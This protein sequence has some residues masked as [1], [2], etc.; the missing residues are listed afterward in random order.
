VL[1]LLIIVGSAI[2]TVRYVGVLGVAVLVTALSA[3]SDRQPTAVHDAS[4]DA[5]TV[6][7]AMTID[8]RACGGLASCRN[9]DCT[10]VSCLAGNP[11]E[12]TTCTPHPPYPGWVDD[13]GCAMKTCPARLTCVRVFQPPNFAFG[14]P[15]GEINRCFEL[16]QSDAGCDSG[17]ICRTNLYGIDVCVAPPAC[18][19][20]ADCAADSCGHC[21][22]KAEIFHAGS[23]ILDRS[24]TSCIYEGPCA[25]NSC[26]DC[27][28]D[29]AHWSPDGFHLCPR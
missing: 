5:P 28:P 8:V 12:S 29:N 15:G 6:G 16:C 24:K 4:V 17:R 13:C 25:A 2:M 27:L 1:R 20:D 9:C 22:P 23:R 19:S 7:D 10:T 11:V 14:G 18:L 26:S 3:C 21:V